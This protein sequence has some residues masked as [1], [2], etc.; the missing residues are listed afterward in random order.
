MNKYVDV[1]APWELAK[2]KSSQK[3]LEAVIYNLIEGLRIISGLI[4]PIMPDTAAK[5]QKHLGMNSE[6]QFYN[7]DR[8]KT[9]KTTKSGT[10]LPKAIRLFPRI[11]LK[12]KDEALSA[13]PQAATTAIDIK[14]QI[15]IEEF[16]KVDLR[17]A[18][19]IDAEAVPK[20]NK[21]LKL[22]VDL[23]ET[24]TLVAGIANSYRPDELI[25]KQVIIV[26]N[27]KPAKLMGIMSHGMVLAS[28]EE[29][30]CSVATLDK[31]VT[32][33]TPLR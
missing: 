11:E 5:M 29:K 4:Y 16:A 20:S 3:Q 7:L 32:P 17:V 19:I 28:S 24:R 21:L 8:L 27:L 2:K 22:K 10:T 1:T 26:A 18:T 13:S 12:P 25:G 6:T 30:G 15:S 14:P 9:W 31:K 33:G 23:G